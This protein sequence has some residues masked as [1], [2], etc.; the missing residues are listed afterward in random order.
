MP[1]VSS[2]IVS[3][4]NAQGVDARVSSKAF[5]KVLIGLGLLPDYPGSYAKD[6]HYENFGFTF[7]QSEQDIEDFLRELDLANERMDTSPTFKWGCTKAKVIRR[8]LAKPW[9]W[10]SIVEQFKAHASHARRV[11]C[12]CHEVGSFKPI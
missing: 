5:E 4:L 1:Q 6:H 10:L 7:I 3:Q 2:E 12:S 8:G 9:G 11:H